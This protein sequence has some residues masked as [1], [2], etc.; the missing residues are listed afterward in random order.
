MFSYKTVILRVFTALFVTTAWYPPSIHS[1]HLQL[2]YW[3][4]GPVAEHRVSQVLLQPFK[5]YCNYTFDAQKDTLNS[6]S[7]PQRLNSPDGWFQL[8]EYTVKQNKT[9]RIRFQVR[10]ERRLKA[11]A[12]FFASE[13]DCFIYRKYLR[14]TMFRDQKYV[15]LQNLPVLSYPEL[16][17][18]RKITMKTRFYHE[19]QHSQW[20]FCI[21]SLTS[22]EF[23]PK[24]LPWVSMLISW[25]LVKSV[26]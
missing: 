4:S 17:I 19:R 18:S 22:S 11:L 15:K 14:H 12:F 2:G 7:L 10:G 16:H 21:K 25:W 5:M 8:S 24:N 3:A 1:L 23:A 9:K 26:A 20:F 6:F 13:T